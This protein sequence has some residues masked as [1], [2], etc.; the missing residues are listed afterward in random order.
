MAESKVIDDPKTG[1]GAD[2]GNA[3]GGTASEV[4]IAELKAELKKVRAEAADRRVKGNELTSA[5]EALEARLAEL[6]EK[7]LPEAEK[8]AKEHERSQ[9]AL[10]GENTK[11][12]ALLEARENKLKSQ[13]VTRQAKAL[14]DELMSEQYKDVFIELAGIKGV[15]EDYDTESVVVLHEGQRLPLKDYATVWL[16]AKGDKARKPTRTADGGGSK[17]A[18]TPLITNVTKNQNEAAPLFAYQLV[19]QALA[20]AG[21]GE[22]VFG[23]AG[24]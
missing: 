13:A 16:D 12:K 5:K 10:K 3:G 18:D 23:S 21:K 17:G 24:S 11:L 14:A 20:K 4:E 1:A 15:V 22:L 7:A 19:E 9:S 6:E 8:K 2:G